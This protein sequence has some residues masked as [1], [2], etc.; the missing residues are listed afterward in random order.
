MEKYHNMCFHMERVTFWLK[1][2]NINLNT[3]NITKIK[4][5]LL[6]PTKK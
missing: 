1:T 4:K 5:L 6:K 3:I 2:R